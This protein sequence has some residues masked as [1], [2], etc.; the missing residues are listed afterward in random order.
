MKIAGRAFS[1][2]MLFSYPSILQLKCGGVLVPQG[3]LWS[4]GAL[5]ETMACDGRVTCQS[6]ERI[7]H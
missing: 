7:I 3:A 2:A 4:N 6:L 5:G 1:L